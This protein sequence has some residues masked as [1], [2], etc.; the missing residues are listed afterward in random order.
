MTH[1]D[2][3]VDREVSWWM[4]HVCLDLGLVAR[5]DLQGMNIQPQ[6][7]GASGVSARSRF[8]TPTPSRSLAS[9]LRSPTLTPRLVGL[10][11]CVGIEF[12]PVEHRDDLV[13]P[14]LRPSTG[15]YV[16]LTQLIRQEHP[17]A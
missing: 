8:T 1:P 11:Q 17:I 2:K 10:R 3:M 15:L 7:S 6:R 12:V 4:T 16:V 9:L 13:N 5:H 14:A